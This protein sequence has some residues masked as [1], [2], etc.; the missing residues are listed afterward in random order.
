[1]PDS[2]GS[3]VLVHRFGDVIEIGPA[4]PARAGRQRRVSTSSSETN[5]P[6]TRVMRPPPCMNSMSPMPSNCSAPCSPRMVRE[7]NLEMTWKEMRVGKFAL[8]VPVMTSTDGRC[9]AMITWMPAARAICARRCTAASISLPATII[10]SAI[11]S[12]TTTMN[13]SGSSASGCSSNVGRPVSE[14]KPVCTRAGNDLALAAGVL[15]AF[16]VAADVAHAELA[17]RAIA[18]F[19]FAH[20]PFQRGHRF[21]RLGDDGR[22][23]MRDAVVDRQFQHLRIDQDQ[24]AL[25]GR[26]PIQQRQD[27]R[28]DADRFAR[29]GGAGDHQMRHARQIGDH[30]LAADILAQRQRQA[31]AVLAHFLARQDFRQ[32]TPSRAWRSAPR[33][34]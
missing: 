2:N 26:Q 1:M 28:V 27:H 13:G 12:T 34:R 20:G 22:H 9:V 14:S 33:C 30:R 16:V 6:C 8:M 10:R 19:H 25:I 23:Q 18:A 11:S 5:G 3:V 31:A 21:G 4:R 29:S 32:D 24:P 7:S 17:H 15:D